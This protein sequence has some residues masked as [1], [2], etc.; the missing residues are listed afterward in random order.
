MNDWKRR[1]GPT[2]G[3]QNKRTQEQRWLV[4]TSATTNYGEIMSGIKGRSDLEGEGKR[5]SKKEVKM[6][7]R[8]GS[9]ALGCPRVPSLFN[10]TERC[11]YIFKQW[12][13]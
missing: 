11:Q 13:A 12:R 2:T 8:L 4:D 6:K 1:R 7:Y 10:L 5:E 9:R 3:Q